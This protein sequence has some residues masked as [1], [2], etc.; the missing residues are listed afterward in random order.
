MAKRQ[1]RRS[2]SVKGITHQRLADH[3]DAQGC[4]VSGWLE[5]VIAEKLDAT[6]VPVPAV[7]R[8]RRPQ[9]KRVDIEPADG[10]DYRGFT[11]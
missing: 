6:G 3:C 2:I 8:P 5:E 10:L 9:T 7:L 4:S 11:F 1:T